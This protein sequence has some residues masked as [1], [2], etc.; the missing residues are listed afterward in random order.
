MSRI[1]PCMINCQEFPQ[2]SEV[3]DDLDG[4]H[5]ISLIEV[6]LTETREKPNVGTCTRIHRRIFQR[7]RASS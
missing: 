2:N 6:D 1:P 3:I 5:A 7:G 4:H